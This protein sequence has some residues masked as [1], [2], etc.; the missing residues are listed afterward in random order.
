VKYLAAALVLIAFIAADVLSNAGLLHDGGNG[1][2]IS[3]TLVM[4]WFVWFTARA[5]RQG[6]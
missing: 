2:D 5:D 6:Q 1:W 4:V 3:L